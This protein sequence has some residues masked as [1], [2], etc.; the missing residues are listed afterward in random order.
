M[1]GGT[2]CGRIFVIGPIG[3]ELYQRRP[4][5]LMLEPRSRA[6]CGVAQEALKQTRQSASTRRQHGPR[7]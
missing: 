4:R 1:G 6:P 7:S 3:H 5:R 2:A